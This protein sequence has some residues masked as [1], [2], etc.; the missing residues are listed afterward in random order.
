MFKVLNAKKAKSALGRIQ[1][2]FKEEQIYQN[3]RFNIV[4]VCFSQ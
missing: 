3:G 1:V 2:V 4:T